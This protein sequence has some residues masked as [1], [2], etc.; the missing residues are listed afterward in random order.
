M[1]KFRLKYHKKYNNLNSSLTMFHFEFE[2]FTAFW[3]ETSGQSIYQ[4]NRKRILC[5]RR[6]DS[7]RGYLAKENMQVHEKVF[8]MSEA[9]FINKDL[10]IKEQVDQSVL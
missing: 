7:C 1:N 8:C 3:G 9:V 6:N 5:R 2:K 4:Y 10:K